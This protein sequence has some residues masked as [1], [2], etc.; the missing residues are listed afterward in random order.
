MSETS[1]SGSPCA[2]DD[3]LADMDSYLD[4]ELADDRAA[5]IRQHLLDCSSCASEYK[6]EHEVKILVARGCA[7]HAPP[8]VHARVRARLRFLGVNCSDR[9]IRED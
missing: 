6:V 5:A 2:C 8:Q 4:K 1:Q 9:E 7:Q 3:V